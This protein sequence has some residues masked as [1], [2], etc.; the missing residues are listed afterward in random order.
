M[1]EDGKLT[2]SLTYEDVPSFGL[3]PPVHGAALLWLIKNTDF[4]SIPKESK[5]WVYERLAKWTNFWTQTHDVD[6]D[7]VVE[8]AGLLETGWEDAPYFNVGFPC[9]SPDLNALVVLQM[10]AL[11]IL[12]GEIGKPQSETDAWSAA[13]KKLTAQIVEKFWNGTEW[14]AF[15]AKTGVKSATHTISLY[16]ALLL[17]ERLPKDVVEKSIA[18]IFADNHFDTKYGLATET[19]DSDYFFHGFTQG[20]VIAPSSFWMAIALEW[21]GRSDLAKKV[22]R[23]YCAMLRDTG[24][25]HIHNSLTGKEDRS[26]TAFGE[27][28]LFW[29]AWAS[30]SFLYLA[31]KY[32]D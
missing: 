25:Y 24:F 12:G 16:F 8:F 2:D 23:A 22:S 1:G 4:R 13:S 30:S 9:A 15:N 3:K 11:A 31:E 26:L 18:Y 10:D 27:K 19:L 7:G 6:G 32:G 14:F 5:E 28:G 29:S 20:S 17:G 21:C